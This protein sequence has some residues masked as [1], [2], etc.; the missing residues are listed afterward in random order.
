MG[1]IQKENLVVKG[2]EVRYKKVNDE[3]YICI[4]DLAKF[5]N[6]KDPSGVIRNWMS[7]KDCF[8]Y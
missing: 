3:D 5:V 4:S 1:N 2:V 7:N 8:H 6:S